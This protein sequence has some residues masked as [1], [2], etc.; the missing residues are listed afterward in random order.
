M[1]PSP[2]DLLAFWRKVKPEFWELASHDIN[3]SWPDSMNYAAEFTR[4]WDQ[5]C[6]IERKLTRT[7]AR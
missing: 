3:T 7:E 6:A 2:K 5:L 4:I 1:V